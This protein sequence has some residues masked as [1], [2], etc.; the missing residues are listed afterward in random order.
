MAIQTQTFSP[1]I[2]QHYVL[3]ETQAEKDAENA[4][5]M[6]LQAQQD[7]AATN[8]TAMGL[9]AHSVIQANQDALTR[10]QNA[11]NREQLGISNDHEQQKLDAYSARIEAD[12]ARQLGQ[13]ALAAEDRKRQIGREDMQDK[14][15]L[16]QDARDATLAGREDAEYQIKQKKAEIQNALADLG[17]G[18]NFGSPDG[19]VDLTGQ[20]ASLTKLGIGGTENAVAIRSQF[21]PNTNQHEIFGEDKSGNAFPLTMGKSPAAFSQD[22]IGL[23]NFAHQASVGMNPQKQEGNHYQQVSKKVTDELG[24]ITEIP[25]G[26]FNQ[27]TGQYSN[28]DPSIPGVAIAPANNAELAAWDKT[29]QQ[30]PKGKASL[31]PTAEASTMQSKASI[32]A[33]PAILGRPMAQSLVLTK[34]ESDILGR[35]PPEQKRAALQQI[36]DSRQSVTAPVEQPPIE[37]V[38]AAPVLQPQVIAAPQEKPAPKSLG[39]NIPENA[40]ITPDEFSKLSDLEQNALINKWRR[41]R[42][43]AAVSSGLGQLNSAAQYRRGQNDAALGS[44]LRR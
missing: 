25:V 15:I 26:S 3:A 13:D 7:A 21:N 43:N 23:F 39:V 18:F 2:P 37:Q 27:V 14:R 9:Q 36:S 22:N 40:G 8:R 44:F 4:R 38:S 32:P 12:N 42:I 20:K 11:A 16:G 1:Y 41:D 17:Q 29:V 5:K 10:E 33:Q 35:L 31:L 28:S 19:V 34:Q 6:A 24:N 30:D